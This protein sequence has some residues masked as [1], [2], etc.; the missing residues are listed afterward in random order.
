MNPA[1]SHSHW[2]QLP[3]ASSRL[4]IKTDQP[5]KP[6][7]RHLPHQLV[8]LNELYDKTEHPSLEERTTLAERLGMYVT[9]S[10][11]FAHH[12]PLVPAHAMVR[13]TQGDKDGQLLVS[14]QTRILEE[15]TQS[16]PYAMRTAAYICSNCLG[17]RSPRITPLTS[18]R[19]RRAVR[20]RIPIPSISFCRAPIAAAT[21][22]ARP[23]LRRRTPAPA[24]V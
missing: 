9:S 8:A 22:A 16:P 4:P 15:A 18:S 23:L 20:G 7:H 21:A 12:P 1:L 14:E 17:L 3:P 6:R 24:P 10:H 11:C 2:D 19:V 13:L 5:K